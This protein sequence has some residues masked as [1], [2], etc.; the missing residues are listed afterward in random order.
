[1]ELYLLRHAIAL[2]REAFDG[3]DDSER[4]LTPDGKKKMQRAAR[5]MLRLGLSFDWILSSPYVRA[6]DTA[7]IVADVFTNRRHLRLTE[8]L[9]PGAD[10]RELVRHLAARHQKHD[11]ML[12]GHE[13]DLSTLLARLLGVRSSQSV[14]M[15]KGALCLLSIERVRNG[16]CARLE[17]MLTPKQLGL[18]KA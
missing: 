9:E 17:W 4:P 10:Q 16:A 11:V 12:V 15:K 18:V 3:D 14:R 7:D 8:L 2:E 13:P 1:M 5:G 6:R